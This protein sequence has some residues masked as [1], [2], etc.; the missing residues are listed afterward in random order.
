MTL[1]PLLSRHEAEDFLFREA[2]L[3]DEDRLEEWLTLFTDDGIYWV[4]SDESIDPDTETSIIYDDSRQ[5][6]KRIFQLRNKHLAQDPPSRTIHYIT[7]VEVVEIEHPDEVQVHCNT[8]ISEMRPGDHQDLQK[9]LAEPRVLAGR[10]IYRLR[11]Q[12][13]DDAWRIAMKQVLLIDRD[14][15]LQNITFIL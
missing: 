8:L 15:P 14:L 3:L 12:E 4:P 5:R 6:E 7:N 10:C 11:Q 9:G 13:N 1:L 2:R